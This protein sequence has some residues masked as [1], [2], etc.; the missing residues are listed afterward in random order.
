MVAYAACIMICRGVLMGEKTLSPNTCNHIVSSYH[1]STCLQAQGS[2]TCHAPLVI[3]GRPAAASFVYQYMY[4]RQLS[5]RDTS[6]PASLS[7]LDLRRALPNVP[8][9]KERPVLVIHLLVLIVVFVFCAWIEI[10][11]H[12]GRRRCLLHGG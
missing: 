1:L 3:L 6:A 4:M 7:S 10:G 12:G 2:L 11:L 5:C 8:Q 9:A